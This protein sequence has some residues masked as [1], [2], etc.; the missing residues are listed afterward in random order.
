MNPVDRQTLLKRVICNFATCSNE[1]IALVKRVL[2]TIVWG[3]DPMEVPVGV[4]LVFPS[5]M[6]IRDGYVRLWLKMGDTGID[7]GFKISADY[8]TIERTSEQPISW[9]KFIVAK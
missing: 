4:N 3:S 5:H 1:D 2:L 6:Q 9:H 8:S 7:H